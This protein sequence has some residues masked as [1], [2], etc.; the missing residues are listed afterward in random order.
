MPRRADPRLDA[1]AA[2]ALGRRAQ[3]E[4]AVICDCPL[5][6]EVGLVVLSDGMG[7]H[8]CGDVAS[9]IVATEVYSELKLRADALSRADADRPGLLR[10][11]AEG[12][13]ACLRAY[14]EA[15]SDA[16]GMGATLLAGILD[17]GALHWISV[18]DSPLY[19]FR[20]GD[21]VRLNA[22]H[23]F[24]AV[25]Q[26]LVAQGRLAAA[27]AE[28]HPDRASLIS[29]LSGG[30]IAHVDCPRTPF[31]LQEGDVLVFAS[32]GLMHLDEAEI[33]RV[34][35]THPEAASAELAAALMGAVETLGDPEQDNLSVAVIRVGASGAG[36]GSGADTR[37]GETETTGSAVAETEAAAVTPDPALCDGTGGGVP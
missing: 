30:P 33:R 24:G 35:R 31:R 16:E 17:G 1:A 7:G 26:A 2:V 19:L 27:T 36:G 13:N 5:G 4:D 6:A 10:R 37:R 11:A 12:A 20:A 14:A 21:L 34:L 3:Q 9:R 22:D 25:M 32:D 29:V 18:G 23:S 8:R 28:G 15:T